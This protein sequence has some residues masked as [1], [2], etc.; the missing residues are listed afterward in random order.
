MARSIDRFKRFLGSRSG[1]IK[2]FRDMEIKL[3]TEKDLSLFKG[4]TKF[5]ARIVGLPRPTVSRTLTFS[6]QGAYIGVCKVRLLDIDQKFLPD[7]A[8]KS[9]SASEAYQVLIN[10]PEA[11]I[12]S[13]V[14]TE[15]LLLGALV[16]CE[17]EEVPGNRGKLRGLVINKILSEDNLEDYQD[18]IIT[19]LTKDGVSNLAELF[20]DG[21]GTITREPIDTSNFTDNNQT[22]DNFEQIFSD[23]GYVWSDIFNIVGIRNTTTAVS[24]KFNDTLWVFYKD[25]ESGKKIAESY[26]ATTVPGFWLNNGTTHSYYK[27][28]IAIMKPGQYI[29]AYVI[30]IHGGK[31][32]AIINRGSSAPSFY[33]DYNQ[34]SNLDLLDSTLVTN[35]YV[36]LNIHSTKE[37]GGGDNVF[38]WS[39][40]CQ[41]LKSWDDFQELM[42]F[43]DSARAKGM[44]FFTYTLF[45]DVD[46]A[47]Q[48][49]AE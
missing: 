36:G 5:Q 22:Y 26:T 8:D 29:D 46:I 30:G 27:E 43:A 20:K 35:K 10:H 28:G 24:N 9:L 37:G 32:E 19:N 34:D 49:V 44:K 39:E 7:P 33:R 2:F 40:G 14:G 13:N 21:Y 12:S 16:E 45:N 17:F 47:Q 23:F 31:Y 15:T 11:L 38:N 6:A 1:R 41:V 42:T 18:S 3:L 4:K 25:N 48:S